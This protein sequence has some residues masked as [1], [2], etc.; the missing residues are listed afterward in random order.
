MSVKLTAPQAALLQALGA[1]GKTGVIKSTSYGPAD[2]LVSYGYALWL[3]KY[4][5]GKTGQLAITERGSA[6]RRGEI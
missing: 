5:N 1:A 4:S 2:A 3:R 6:F